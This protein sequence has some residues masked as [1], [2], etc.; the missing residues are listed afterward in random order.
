MCRLNSSAAPANA[1][2]YYCTIP[3]GGD[4]PT[5]ASAAQ[6]NTLNNAGS[7]GGG[8][9]GRDVRLF[10][11]FDYAINPSFLVGARLGYVLNSYNG[12][13]AV[14]DGHAFSSRVHFEVR[15]TYLFGDEPLAHSGLAPYVFAGGG[16]AE[17]DAQTRVFVTQNGIP[18]EGIMQAWQTAG[19]GFISLGGGVRYGF[20]P[21]AA[22]LFGLRAAAVFGGA[23]GLYTS[24]APE[25]S[26]QY[27]F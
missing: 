9:T 27:G 19:P 1:A 2:G 11:T 23:G 14:T 13:A 12:Q 7:V 18:G 24:Y 8:P 6:N 4:F 21:R 20:S 5:R 10:A 16:L 26:V 3:D 15:G 22:F 25:L 17:F